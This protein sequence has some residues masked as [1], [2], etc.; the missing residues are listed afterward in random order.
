MSRELKKFLAIFVGLTAAFT[1]FGAIIALFVA[2]HWIIGIVVS[3]P[4]IAGLIA[5][6]ETDMPVLLFNLWTREQSND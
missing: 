1:L 4:A 2:E 6:I 3:I 5:A